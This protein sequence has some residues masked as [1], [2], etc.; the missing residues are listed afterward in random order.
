MSMTGILN[1]SVKELID[2]LPRVFLEKI[3]KTKLFEAGQEKNKNRIAKALAD[4]ILSDNP[5]PFVWADKNEEGNDISIEF[6]E[7]DSIDLSKK[8]NAFIIDDLPQIISK[9]TNDTARDVV[10]DLRKRWPEQQIWEQSQNFG[11]RARLELR[12][13]KGLDELRMQLVMCREIGQKISDKLGRSQAKS[14]ITKRSVISLLH[15]RACQTQLEIITLLENGLADGALSRWRTL[16]EIC[17]VA[18]IISKHGD[19]LAQRYIDHEMVAT[20]REFDND[21][22]SYPNLEIDD[23]IE[24]AIAQDYDSVLNKYGKEFGSTYGWAAGAL[25]RKKPSFQNLESAAGY[26][27][28]PPDYKLASYKIH[29]GVAGINFNLGQINVLAPPIAGSSNA[30][31]EVPATLSAFTLTQITSLLRGNSTKIDTQIELRTLILVRDQ[32]QRVFRKF[33]KRLTADE[34]DLGNDSDIS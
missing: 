25:K 24:D 5:E 2:D 12:W 14:G 26:P 32:I 22:K 30:G 21:C 3:I 27:V 4:H 17:I 23:G 31:L 9:T 13:G 19:D 20:K 7:Q 10:K 15:L 1:S 29:A 16:Y 11:F 33:A 18:M 8:I 6:T 34:M 28:L